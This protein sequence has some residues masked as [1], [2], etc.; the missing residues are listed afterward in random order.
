V[1]NIVL[2]DRMKLSDDGLIVIV[3]SIDMKNFNLLSGPDVISRGFIFVR[4]SGDLIKETES[5][6][7][8][9][10]QELMDQKVRSWSNIKSQVIDTIA[11]F[12]YKKIQRRPMIIPI[13]MEV[14]K[15]DLVKQQQ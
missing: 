14:T 9:L 4:E 15:E 8:V 6:V 12:I 3:M 2:R 1:G 13:I 10:V 11:P 7:K 5:K